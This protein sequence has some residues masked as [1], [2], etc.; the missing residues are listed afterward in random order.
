MLLPT[1]KTDREVLKLAVSRIIGA[2]CSY[3]YRFDENAF[4]VSQLNDLAFAV[5][6]GSEGIGERALN[7]RE[8][9]IVESPG[10]PALVDQFPSFTSIIQ[11]YFGKQHLLSAD[12]RLHTDVLY[13]SGGGTLAG[14]AK[15]VSE[16]IGHTVSS[17]GIYHYLLPVRSGTFESR[18]HLPGLPI[19]MMKP[20]KVSIPMLII[21]MRTS[22]HCEHYGKALEIVVLLYRM[23]RK[24][25]FIPMSAQHCIFIVDGPAWI[26]L[27]KLVSHHMI[28]SHHYRQQFNPMDF[29]LL[30]LVWKIQNAD[31]MSHIY[32]RHTQVMLSSD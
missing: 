10:R 5:A 3:L 23:M 6:T 28:F 13:A 31:N 14:C 27:C 7:L 19:R 24:H 4:S 26:Q 29:S 17:S 21:S 15:Y 25:V 9:L 16:R 20:T 30:D 12:P 32:A 11:E 2:D 8:S 22:K 1:T 18:R